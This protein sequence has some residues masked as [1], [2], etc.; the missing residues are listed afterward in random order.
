MK[1]LN[2][3]DFQGA[4]GRVKFDENRGLNKPAS[5]A[6]IVDGKTVRM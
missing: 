6:K 3:T 2:N 4:S 5:L 1:A